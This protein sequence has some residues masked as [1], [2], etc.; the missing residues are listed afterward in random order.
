MPDVQCRDLTIHYDDVGE[1]PPIVWVPGTGLRGSTREFQVSRFRE[2]FRCLTVDLRGSGQTSYTPGPFTVVDLAEDLAAWL[3]GIAV[4]SAV[5][6]GLS[7]GSAVAQELALARPDLVRGLVL[8]ATWSSTRREHHIR[9]H[10]ESRLY[11]LEHG[12]PD[13]YAQFGF[14]MSAP[15]LL[16]FEPDRQADVERLLTA[17]MSASP[18]GTAGHFRAD[19]G[20]ET[21][22]RLP[23]IACPCLV[24]HGTEDLITLPW[25]NRTVAELIPGAVR[26]EIPA[27]GH[28]AWLERPDE[29][30][31]HIGAF[32]GTLATSGQEARRTLHSG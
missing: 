17:H 4:S 7:L 9:R 27:A 6:I 30:N 3:D 29:L 2:R 23:L 19:L 13:V 8:L 32:L 20:H 10:F 24:V 12:P 21:R 11:A 22:D 26:V 16:D 1:G 5:V 14:W 28:L 31:E 25:Y 18:A 15:S